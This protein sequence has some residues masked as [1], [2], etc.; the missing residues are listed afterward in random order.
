MIQFTENRTDKYPCLFCGK[1]TNI[2][3]FQET[4]KMTAGYNR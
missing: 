2:K 3:L 1:D 4:I